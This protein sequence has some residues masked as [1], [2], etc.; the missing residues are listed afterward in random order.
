M[1]SSYIVTALRTKKE[2]SAAE[3]AWR[4]GNQIWLAGAGLA[5]VAYVLF[6]GQFLT[7]SADFGYDNDEADE[8]D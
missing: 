3:K 8:D 5:L 7:I 1:V 6:S 4:Q 2:L